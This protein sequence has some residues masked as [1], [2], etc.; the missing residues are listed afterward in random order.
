VAVT[1]SSSFEL[2][3][4]TVVHQHVDYSS[5]RLVVGA[6]VGILYP[7]TDKA[8]HLNYVGLSNRGVSAGVIPI[9]EDDALTPAVSA[10]DVSV[11]GANFTTLA[12]TINDAQEFAEAV[13]AA[14]GN[15]GGGL[16]NGVNIYSRTLMFSDADVD[17]SGTTATISFE[18]LDEVA[19]GGA[20]ID[21]GA[22][23]MAAFNAG[24][25]CSLQLKVNNTNILENLSTPG[26]AAA[27]DVG[28]TGQVGAECGSV[29]SPK[30][31]AS[32][33][34]RDVRIV[35]TSTGANLGTAT[36][37]RASSGSL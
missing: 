14:L 33:Y 29:I 9:A 15:V 3:G 30:Y 25:G 31:N 7:I 16:P 36:T 22:A 1:S 28:A 13:D 18:G 8:R 35:L 17:I 24:S 21:G 20:V 23:L 19:P 5:H 4:V 6:S 12:G 37:G 11:S 2:N 26:S 10:A 34:G 27:L 32:S